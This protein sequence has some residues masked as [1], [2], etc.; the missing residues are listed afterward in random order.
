MSL[1]PFSSDILVASNFPLAAC[2]Y[3]LSY[4]V[5]GGGAAG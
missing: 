5:A 3:S 4:W 1:E 2:F